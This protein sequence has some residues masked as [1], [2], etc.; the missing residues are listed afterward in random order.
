MAA[1]LHRHA[2]FITSNHR[3]AASIELELGRSGSKF[4]TLSDRVG[5]D[6]IAQAFCGWVSLNGDPNGQPVKAPTYLGDDTAGLH[7]ALG[8]MV[9]LRHRDQT[10]EGQ[11]VDVALVRQ[12]KRR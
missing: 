9:A 7:A 5:Y 10:G 4:G 12:S 6:P 3:C 2:D 11:H 1:A 8:A